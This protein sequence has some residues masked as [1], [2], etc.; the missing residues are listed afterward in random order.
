[1]VRI[2]NQADSDRVKTPKG[3]R[4]AAAGR[5]GST[6]YYVRGTTSPDS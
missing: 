6:R 2:H 4:F 1:M 3:D 5:R